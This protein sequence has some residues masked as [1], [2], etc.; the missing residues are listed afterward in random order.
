MPKRLAPCSKFGGMLEGRGT[1]GFDPK[2]CDSLLSTLN[3][4]RSAELKRPEKL[5]RIRPEIFDFELDLGRKRRQ[6]KP[7]IHGTVPTDRLTT[8]PNDSGTVSSRF[9]DP[10]K[11]SNCKIAQPSSVRLPF[12]SA[13]RDF[14]PAQETGIAPRRHW[15]GATTHFAHLR[16]H[17]PPAK[18]D[19]GHANR[20]H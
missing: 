1:E 16:R 20:C 17:E 5:S 8:I 18:V 3:T 12:A 19:D 2:I 6:A 14:S 4:L 7:K 13:R 15:L 11:P 9:D 10:P